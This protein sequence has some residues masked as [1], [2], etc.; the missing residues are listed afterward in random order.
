MKHP[1]ILGT[2]GLRCIEGCGMSTQL[3]VEL[4]PVGLN[5]LA[6]GTRVGMVAFTL[7]KGWRSAR[8]PAAEG[9]TPQEFWICQPCADA[10]GGGHLQDDSRGAAA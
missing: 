4:L 6:D 5:R 9:E 1:L 8:T 10:K 7:P 3:D 2:L